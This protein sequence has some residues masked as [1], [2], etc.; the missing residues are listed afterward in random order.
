MNKMR[1]LVVDFYDSFVFN[2]VHYF[3]TQRCQ[4]EVLT[5]RT[6]PIQDLSFL[7]NYDGVILSPGPGLPQE[8]HS[9]QA[10]ISFCRGK[11]P[12]FGVCLGMQGIGLDL[13]GELYN[14]AQI[15]HGI[16]DHVTLNVKHVLFHNL[17][18]E[19]QVGL[20]H[21]WAIK[22]VDSMLVTAVDKE[23]VIMA[24]ENP[25]T[26]QYG[27]QFHPESVMTT[28]GMEIVKNVISKIF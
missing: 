1:V 16:T 22:N 11:I 3:E 7:M 6:I 26:K 20:Y 13:G 15:R 19:I 9:M 14:L 21:S 5:D 4:V 17:P 10:I 24:I 18:S 27:V 23:G 25:H 2:L 8:T 12:V 28:L